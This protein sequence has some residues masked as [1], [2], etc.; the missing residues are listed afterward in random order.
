[1]GFFYFSVFLFLLEGIGLEDRLGNFINFRKPIIGE[2]GFF[3]S[4]IHNLVV[5]FP[6]SIFLF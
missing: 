6:F 2:E 3:P 5:D 4:F 1:M